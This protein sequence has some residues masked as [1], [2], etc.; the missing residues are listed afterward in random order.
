MVTNHAWRLSRRR[1]ALALGAVALTLIAPPDRTGT[2]TAVAA[3]AR[4]FSVLRIGYQR[5]GDLNVLKARGTLE[6]RLAPLGISIQWT[7][8]P[9][10]PQL[11]EALNVGSIDFGTTGEAPPIF[12]QAAGAPLV[13]VASE[14]SAPEGEAILVPKTSPIHSVADLKG[15]RVAFNKGSNVNYLVVQA[16]AKAGLTYSDIQ[17]VYLVPADARAAFERGSVDAWAIWDPYYAVEQHAIPVRVLVDG[18]GL[19]ANRQFY[20]ASRTLAY[21]HRNVT[22]IIVQ[23]LQS[24]DSW[25]RSNPSKVASFLAPQIGIDVADVSLSIKRSRFGAVPITDAVIAGQQRIADTFYKL[26][27][28]PK[29]IRV[30]DAEWTATGR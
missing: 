14:P 6:K 16:L 27:L 20:L 4:G 10:G 18:R 7:L 28:I 17:P 22:T 13:Y 9:A 23:Q 21:D 26:G 5:F 3:S 19:V 24:A 25:V 8:F 29:S 2:M 12:A 30:K 1:L 11:L 15:K